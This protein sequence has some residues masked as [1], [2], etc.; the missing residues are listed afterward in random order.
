MPED[1]AQASPETH[2][3]KDL[4]LVRPVPASLAASGLIT[5]V[6]SRYHQNREVLSL[7]WMQRGDS[8]KQLLE[9]MIYTGRN[10]ENIPGN[11]S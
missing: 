1:Q 6:K 8:P 4:T 3:S 7:L 5:R 2:T 11:G 9:L 10:W